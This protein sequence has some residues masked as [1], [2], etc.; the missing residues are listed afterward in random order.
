MNFKLLRNIFEY[1]ILSGVSGV[2]ILL[3][4]FLLYSVTHQLNITAINQYIA[5]FNKDN[6]AIKCSYILLIISMLIKIGI[7]PMQ[8]FIIE[9]YK[10]TQPHF[11]IFLSI[12]SSVYWFFLIKI[13]Y[14]IFGFEFIEQF[15]FLAFFMKLIGITGMVFYSVKIIKEQNLVNFLSYILIVYNSFFIFYVPYLY[16]H[17]IYYGVCIMLIANIISKSIIFTMLATISRNVSFNTITIDN[18][19][20]IITENKTT[21]RLLF[22]SFF[23]ISGLP[24][25]LPFVG[26]IS[27]LTGMFMNYNSLIFIFFIFAFIVTIMFSCLKWI[28]AILNDTNSKNNLQKYNIY[29]YKILYFVVYLT[30]LML[31]VSPLL[32]RAN[33]IFK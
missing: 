28:V 9:I 13:I 15:K 22:M 1:L 20:N 12:L 26:K 4:I 16:I 31:F 17:D 5:S 23:L 18:I 27:I 21:K 25:S 30:T 19:N 29:S 2:I 7:F 32:I 10:K 11:M 24:F 14:N 3:S 8:S 33:V 6:I